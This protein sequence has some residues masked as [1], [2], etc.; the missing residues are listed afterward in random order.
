MVAS[1]ENPLN[2]EETPSQNQIYERMRTLRQQDLPYANVCYFNYTNTYL[3][4]SLYQIFNIKLVA[5]PCRFQ[6][7]TWEYQKFL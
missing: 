3:C 1:A 2:T 6:C 5:T 4:F 7:I